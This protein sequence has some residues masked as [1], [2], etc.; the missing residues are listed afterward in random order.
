MD[1]KKILAVDDHTPTSDVYAEFLNGCGY[2][3]LKAGRAG[4]AILH[5]H[6]HRPHAVSMNVSMP[7]PGGIEPADSPPACSWVA[8]V[9]MKPHPAEEVAS[10]IRS[11][12][13]VAA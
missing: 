6:Q 8:C 3:V 12:A 2:V 10:R 9:R 11:L 7:S 4:E 5:V 1:G 13:A